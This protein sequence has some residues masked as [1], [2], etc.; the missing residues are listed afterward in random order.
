[1]TDTP[2][3]KVRVVTLGDRHDFELV[4]RGM[5]AAKSGPLAPVPESQGAATLTVFNWRKIH[6]HLVGCPEKERSAEFRR[7]TAVKEK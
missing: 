6:A 5:S 7:F 1:M 2:A 3:G 4:I